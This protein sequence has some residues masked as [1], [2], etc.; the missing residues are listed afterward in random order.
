MQLVASLPAGLSTGFARAVSAPPPAMTPQAPPTEDWYVG[1]GGVPLGP[2]RLAVIREKALSGSVDGESLVWREGFDEWQPLKTFP[3]LLAMIDEV[4]MQPGMRP[5]PV[6]G[7]V[8]YAPRQGASPDRSPAPRQGYGGGTLTTTPRVETPPSSAAAASAANA[9]ADPFG[10]KS[11]T[12]PPATAAV[13]PLSATPETPT[14]G[15]AGALAAGTGAAAMGVLADPFSASLAPPAVA[16]NAPASAF[17]ATGA[18]GLSESPFVVRPSI[19]SI[20]PPKRDRG[21][22]PMAWAFIAMCAA[23]G[24]VA[25]WAVFLRSPPKSLAQAATGAPTS[26]GPLLGPAPP[27][28]AAMTDSTGN[29]IASPPPTGATSV[30]AGTQVY[31]S[32]GVG[33][34]TAHTAKATDTG[35][36][37]DRSGFGSTSS[38]GPSAT[39]DTNTGGGGG[40][41]SEGEI[42]GVVN[43]NK[44]GISRR[45]WDPAFD[46]SDGKVKSAKVSANVTIGPSGSVQ[47]VSAG[48]GDAFPGLAS[49]VAGSIRAWQFPP[50]DSPTPVSI[51]FGFN[52][53]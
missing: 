44:P 15:V 25:A 22:H 47:S 32:G 16:G 46:Q 27:P 17:A 43:R 8:G 35:T 18:A 2:V 30:A 14:P 21:L 7:A 49:C 36:P 24:A 31:P 50:S 39:G 42:S 19:T 9:F 48:G 20:P 12:P 34:G 45:C 29:P 41:L 40:Q 10:L 11:A 23:F 4:R 1:V 33:A 51:P 3:A 26:T 37:I 5:T 53:Q 28:P 38:N 52:H 6:P 13:L